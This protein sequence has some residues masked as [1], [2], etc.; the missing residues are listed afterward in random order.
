MDLGQ[1]FL[2]GFD[3]CEID[4]QHPVVE[5][6][7][8]RRAGGVILFARNVDGSRQNIS[9]PQQ[10]AKLTLDLQRYAHTELLIAVDQEGGQVCRL[11]EQ[12][13]FS[14]TVSA[15]FLGQGDDIMETAARSGQLAQ[16]LK[17]CGVNFNLA[18]VVD[19]DRNPENPVIGRFG[20]SFGSDPDKVIRHSSAF[21]AEHHK[22]NICCCLKHFPGH[23]SS[24]QDSHLGFTDVSELWHVDELAPYRSLIKQGCVDA[25]MSAHV[26]NR[27][28]DD[29]GLPATLS[30]RMLKGILRQEL[31]FEGVI[32]SDD[33]QMRAITDEWSLG[34][35]VCSAVKA[36]VDLL[37]IGNNLVRDR[38]S[39]AEAISALQEAITRKEISEKH[40]QTSLRRI[41]TLKQKIA[42]IL[43]G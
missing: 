26:V 15:H 24:G 32:I 20:R 23:G 38:G 16:S 2:I 4:D 30:E 42:G 40:I 13:G 39:L 5:D 37:V 34:Q 7:V 28:L 6:I 11:R 8:D 36:G 29:S 12:D 33:L 9:S 18:P 19:L 1:L 27:R 41:S 3:G 22:K 14:S 31:G 35:A 17:D 10:L 25:V 43:P 21:I